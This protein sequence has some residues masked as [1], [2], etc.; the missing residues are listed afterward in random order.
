LRLKKLQPNDLLGELKTLDWKTRHQ[1]A[2]LE[3]AK[4][5]WL[6]KADQV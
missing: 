6:W 4:A 3:N 2:S 1:S 5:N